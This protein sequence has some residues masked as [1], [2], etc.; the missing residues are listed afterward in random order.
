LLTVQTNKSYRIY[1]PASVIRKMKRLVAFPFL[2][3]VIFWLTSQP[4][5]SFAAAL[6]VFPNNYGPSALSTFRP[7]TSLRLSS[8]SSTDDNAPL[9]QIWTER[10]LLDFAEKQGMILSLSTLGPG[11]RAVARAQHNTSQILGYCEGFLRPPGQPL[12]LDKMEVFR[13]M[14]LQTKLENGNVFTGGGSIFGPGLLLGFLCLLHGK[15]NGYYQAEFLAIDD[16]EKQHKKLVNYYARS[17]FKIIKY[18]GDD[19]R[20]IPARM[21]WGGCGT[22]MRADIDEV[23]QS[24]TVILEKSEFKSHS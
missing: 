9:V 11:Y 24:W 10:R 1:H 8:I 12:H 17:G 15:N 19:F 14:V 13:K 4:S 2:R 21:V 7:W 18:V 3:A 23:L 5:L 6:I 16:N 22:L 20:D